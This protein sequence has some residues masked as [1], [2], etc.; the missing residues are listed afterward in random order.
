M[1]SCFFPSLVLGSVNLLCGLSPLSAQNDLTLHYTRP[2]TEWVEALP[3]G[4]GRLGAMVF[5]GIHQERLQLNEDTLWAGGPYDPANPE[6]LAALPE[7]RRLI[8]KGDYAAAQTLAG[9]KLMARPLQQAPYQTVGDLMFTF[10]GGDEVNS[11]RRELNL[12]TAVARTEYRTGSGPWTITHSREVFASPVDQVIVVRLTAGM[13]GRSGGG[14]QL[15][16]VLGA[17]SPQ[18]ANSHT[19]GDNTLVLEG[20]NGSAGKTAGARGVA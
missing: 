18:Q 20:R 8:E 13:A 19:E 4:N 17:E 7:V 12:D 1:K 3:V 2:A 5:G 6:A 10:P 16:F 15:N 9:Q 11:Y 14:G